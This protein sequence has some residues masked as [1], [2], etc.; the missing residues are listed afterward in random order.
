MDPR[1]LQTE[2]LYEKCFGE[3]YDFPSQLIISFVCPQPMRLGLIPPQSFPGGSDSKAFACNADR[4]GFN[5]WVGKIPWRRAWQPMPVFLP[6]ESPWTEEPGRYS[7]L[8]G[9]QLYTTEQLSTAQRS[10]PCHDLRYLS[11]VMRVI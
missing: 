1:K 7:A 6:G 10:T 4:P 3:I 9:K 5:P 2:A 8:G 11:R